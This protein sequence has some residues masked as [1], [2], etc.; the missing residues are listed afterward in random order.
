M[1]DE[2]NAVVARHARPPNPLT[3][4]SN[5]SES[6]KLFERLWRNYV[7]LTGLDTKPKD[8]QVAMLESHLGEEALRIY[9]GLPFDSTPQDRTMEEILVAM[10]NYAVGKENES[11][12]R[13]IFR[14]KYQEENETFN[15]FYASLRKLSGS[16]NFCAQCR[17]S[18]IRDQI[19]I[20]IRNADTREE[21][22]KINPLNLQKCVDVCKAAESAVSHSQQYLHRMEGTVHKVAEK[23]QPQAASSQPRPAKTCKFC[24][25]THEMKIAFCPAF[26]KTC[27]KCGKKNHF[28][29]CCYSKVRQVTAEEPEWIN[30]IRNNNV[31]KDYRCRFTIEGKDVVFQLDSG[32]TVNLLPRCHAGRQLE[33][34]RGKL[35]TWNNE[36]I[37]PAGMCRQIIVNPKDKKR[38][39]VEF[40]VFEDQF[41]QPILGLRACEQM[42]LLEMKADNFERVLHIEGDRSS[43]VFDDSLGRLPGTQ[44]LRLKEGAI[45]VVMPDRRIPI[46][47]QPKLDAELKRLTDMGVI[48]PVQEPTPWLSQI[49]VAVKKNGDLRVCL[50]PHEVNKVLIREHTTLPILEDVLHKM[51]D[52]TVFSKADLASAYW[53]VELDQE[54]SFLTTFSTHRGRY[55]WL[56]LPFGLCVAS[57]I[58]YQKLKECIG[59][60]PGVVFLADDIIVFGGSVEE[61]DK[62]YQGFLQRCREV[63]IRLNKQKLEL[64]MEHVDFMGHRIGKGVQ[65]DPSK[66]R[67]ITKMKPPENVKELRQFIGM[68]NFLGKF[69]RNLSTVIA[70]LTRLLKKEVSWNWSSAQQEAFQKLKDRLTS[71]P[72]L[73]M[74]DPLREVTLENDASEFGIGSALMQG[75][76]PVAYASRLLSES[77]RRYAQIEK[78]MLAVVFGLERFHH[79]VFG[80][81]VTVVTDHKPLVSISKK[82]L[83][84]APRR[85]Q[86]L[87]LRAQHYCF[88]VVYKPG[89]D[90]PVA[91]FLSRS[92]C[93]KPIDEDLVNAVT[94]H[95]AND[96]R[97]EQIRQATILDPELTELG[98]TILRGWARERTDVPEVLRP[99]FPFRDELTVLEGIIYRGERIVV[100]HKLRLL[101]K[102]KVHAGH[103]GINAS[104]RRARSTLYWP[105]ISA[106]IRQFIEACDVCASYS[107]KQAREPLVITESPNRPW[108]KI[109][110][111][112]FSFGGKN[113]LITV[114]YTSSFTE[115][116]ELHSTHAE[117]I[118]ICLKTHFARYGI[119]QTVVTDNGPQFSAGIFREFARKWQFSHETI[120]PGNS[121]ANGAAERA[122]QTIKQLW[123]KCALGKEDEMLGLLNLR[124]TPCEGNGISPAVCLLGH[125]TQ[126]HI[127]QRMSSTT[128]LDSQ[129][130]TEHNLKKAVGGKALAPLAPKDHVRVQP[131]D[132]T[133]QWKSGQVERQLTGRSY[134]VRVGG[135]LLRRNRRMLRHSPNAT[136]EPRTVVH[137][138]IPDEST[139]SEVPADQP[140][141]EDLPHSVDADRLLERMQPVTHTRSGRAVKRPERLIET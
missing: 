39:S 79:Y 126:S 55:R 86:N 74:Y 75:G 134:E 52:A 47:V 8:I 19:V 21:L 70:P 78:E 112:L 33:P 4:T 20:G 32:S 61:H 5:K 53:H 12:E 128:C 29:S 114:D 108:T 56:R 9:D 3:F 136:P 48:T 57:E 87:S 131:I 102:Q 95:P 141:M 1:A 122:V 35:K 81:A 127:P 104:L 63:G 44:S 45:P 93:D 14:T 7:K 68:V 50:D 18:E 67:A 13:F 38:F 65:I 58:L 121:Q 82:P 54:A 37:T 88:N 83:A 106:E 130:K 30:N 80:R 139:V 120:S 36:P 94:L 137:D 125:D 109:G 135:R 22:L 138:H 17:D 98:K 23:T 91:D 107:S 99:Y 97:L 76:Q 72:V 25:R 51:K 103:I 2:G 10:K 46:H 77:E 31:S 24:G 41:C 49:V 123:R 27:S 73:R 90:I 59:D 105:G 15:D 84:K 40:V 140:M 11:Y 28:A 92:P 62:H 116:D 64:R 113:Y 111:D 43:D 71:A 34:Y 110:S 117:S 133:R 26:G 60:L 85:L 101:M 118:I 66:V 69:M 42:K 96:Q 129:R 89:K 100:P 6:W 124:N 115:V 16:C 132:N 119:P